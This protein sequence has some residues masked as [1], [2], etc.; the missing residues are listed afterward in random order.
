MHEVVLAVQPVTGV[1][2]PPETAPLSRMTVAQL[3][4]TQE[5]AF[6]A[7]PAVPLNTT[8][9]NICGVAVGVG[10][11]AAVG[12]GVAVGVAVGDGSSV[13]PLL[14]LA[15]QPVETMANAI[16]SAQTYFIIVVSLVSEK[17]ACNLK[18]SKRQVRD[19]FCLPQSWMGRS[20]HEHRPKQA[21]G[22]EAARKWNRR[23]R[24][25]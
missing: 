10:V 5:S 24:Q 22:T 25:S 8:E 1:Y 18:R 19:S 12:R 2:G 9:Q 17:L 20:L 13:P 7:S 14:P 15:P 4:A 16:D 3:E 23:T 6:W 11:G 21:A